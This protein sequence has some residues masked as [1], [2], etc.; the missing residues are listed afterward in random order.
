MQSFREP[1]DRVTRFARRLR[2]GIDSGTIPCPTFI[3]PSINTDSWDVT[4][5]EAVDFAAFCWQIGQ[6]CD[7]QQ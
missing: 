5:D 4:L 3:N 2:L 1:E 6:L 7:S